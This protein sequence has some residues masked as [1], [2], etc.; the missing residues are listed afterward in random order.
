[1]IYP[2]LCKPTGSLPLIGQWRAVAQF[3]DF[4]KRNP[5]QVVH[6]M[7]VSVHL[8]DALWRN[9]CDVMRICNRSFYR[10]DPGRDHWD[11]IDFEN[12]GRGDCEDFALTWLKMLRER[13][14]P[15]GAL[16]LVIATIPWLPP[17]QN[18]HAIAVVDCGTG[19]LALDV[20][21]IRPRPVLELE[22]A[23][24]LIL[25]WEFFWQAIQGADLSALVA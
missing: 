6:D 12:L 15:A 5:D 20:L 17:Q 25:Q 9:L 13:G 1:M 19:Q 3:N 10:H 24:Q 18:G 14:V 4:G 2:P 22:Y 8:D 7:P 21:G 23:W 16:H 11:I